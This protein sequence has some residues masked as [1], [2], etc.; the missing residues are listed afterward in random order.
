MLFRSAGGA[1]GTP[2]GVFGTAGANN[3]G[4]G[5]GGGG[6]GPAVDGNGGA[7]G[8]GIVIVSI[9]TT[10][11]SVDR[12][13]YTASGQWTAPP[14]ITAVDYVLVAGGGGGGGNAPNMRSAGGGGAGG[15]LTGT[16]FPVAPG[17]TYPII[18][19]SGGTGGTPSITGSNG[20][21]SSFS[22]LTTFGG[23]I[24]RAHV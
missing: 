24:G 7:G 20:T 9:P 6:A 4:G 13:I 12:Y 3:T 22:S 21:N 10:Q 18:I 17:Q 14:G 23:E 8:S 2:T 11:P 5:G 16:G 15:Y 19:G 1:G